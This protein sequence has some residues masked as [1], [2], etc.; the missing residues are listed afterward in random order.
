M[1]HTKFRGNRPAGSGEKDF[2]GFFFII[3]GNSGQLG[4]VT[5][6]MSSG[7]SFHKRFGSNGLLLLTFRSLAAIVSKKN[8]VVT[9]SY[10]K[11]KLKNLT[12][13]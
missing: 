9:F 1:L 7:E 3:Y 2:K 5:S 6:I 12:L 10:R 13:P 11:A 8:T 4:H